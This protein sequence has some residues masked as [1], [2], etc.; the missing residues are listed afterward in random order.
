VRLNV[1]D[2]YARSVFINCPFDQQYKPLFDAIVF[3]VQIAGYKPRCA[4]EV[5]NAAQARIEKLLDL[6]NQCRLGIHDIS[7]TQLSKHGLPRF[8]MP[9]ELGMDIACRRFGGRHH[10]KKSLLVMDKTPFRYQKFI[11][12]I[13]GQ[14]IVPH[15]NSQREIIRNVRDWLASFDSGIPGGAYIY[16][17]FREFQRANPKI[18]KI[19]KLKLSELTF[20]DF[21]KIVRI[22]LEETA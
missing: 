9:F 21:T 19:Q 15:N 5:S 17:R 16:R 11:S 22:F 10:Q 13:A 1:T 20:G 12:D 6:I 14:D 7:R 4:R 18:C 2:D 8:N 3:T